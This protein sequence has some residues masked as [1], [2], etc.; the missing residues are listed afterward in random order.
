M[1]RHDVPYAIVSDAEELKNGLE[2]L[3]VSLTASEHRALFDYLDEVSVRDKSRDK[4]VPG[5]CMPV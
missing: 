3:G 4:S 1:I 2:R 5:E